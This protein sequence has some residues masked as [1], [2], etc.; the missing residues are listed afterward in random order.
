MN[1]SN[2]LAAVITIMPSHCHLLHMS[3]DMS[4]IVYGREDVILYT[5]VITN[6]NLAQLQQVDQWIYGR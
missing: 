2:L 3:E 1:W 6:S 5:L 4:Q